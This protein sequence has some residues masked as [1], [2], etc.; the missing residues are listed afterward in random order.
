MR[1]VRFDRYGG[2]DVLT[3]DEVDKPVPAEDQ[4]LVAVRAAG[5]N[6]FD[7]KLRSGVFQNDFTI[8]FPAPQGTDVAGVVEA[9]GPGVEGFAVGDEVLGSTGKRG[10]QADFALLPVK[11][12]LTRPANLAWEVA[13]SFWT[14]ASAAAALVA[15]AG[16]GEG[17]NV[18]VAGSGGVGGL[19]CQLARVRGAHVICVTDADSQEWLRSVG[20]AP[21]VFGEGAR[22]R[23]VSA[24]AGAKLDA[25]LD[26]AGHGYVELA[27]ELGV[28]PERIDTIVD[29]AG[30]ERYGAKTD[31][32]DAA[33]T[34]EVK[35][36]LEQVATGAVQFPID[37]T[38]PL[39]RVRE[40]YVELEE[41]HP[42]G[43]IVIVP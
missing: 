40:A 1:Q 22:E 27:V 33:S 29:F 26:T 8:P 10:S 7:A 14:V 32:A 37:A 35:E 15:A 41:R 4:L 36:V 9:V 43:K 17:D 6:P 18:L 19:A 16:V 39:D 23:I 5:A 3:V 34:P 12:A 24:L 38:F 2:V 28:A 21:V 13:G 31:G 42:R 25:L 30:A 20:V 11:T